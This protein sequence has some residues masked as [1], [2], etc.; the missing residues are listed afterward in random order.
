MSERASGMSGRALLMW[1]AG[2]VAY[3]GAVF[4][5]SSLAVAGVEAADRFHVGAAMLSMLSVVQLAV[6]AAMQVPAGLL[7]D[8]H[9]PRRLLAIGSVLMAAGQLA[10]ALATGIWPALGARMLIGIGD[11]LTFVSLVRVVAAWFPARRNPLLVQLTGAIGQL[12]S[13]ASAVPLVILLRDAGWTVTFLAASGLAVAAAVI[14]GTALRDRPEPVGVEPVGVDAG[15]LTG[16]AESTPAKSSLP[17][18]LA[19]AWAQPGTKLGLWTHFATQFSGTVF[20]LLWG[21]P[22]LLAEGLSPGGAAGMLSLLTC[23]G[24]VAG[25]VIGQLC[26]R[27]PFHRSALV[28]A[29]VGSSAAMWTV[30]LSWPGRVPHWALVAL[31]LVLAVNGPGSM[32]G[33][34]Y[35]RTFN[36]ARRL[37]SATGIVNVGGFTASILLIIGIG[38]TVDAL[39]PAG[40]DGYPLGVLRWAFALQYLLW[41]LGVI[42]VL[43]LRRRTRR[44]LA[45]RDPAAVP[46][47]ALRRLVPVGAD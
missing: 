39:R 38:V 33:F 31:V 32:I 29:I 45:I 7:L 6:Y 44:E 24:I 34:D 9:G 23:A 40:T 26:G 35:A 27:H 12:G 22:F 41:G 13:L 15:V 21:Y 11:A 36:P 5:R 17:A 8:R 3:V 14:V 16:T 28:L 4:Q 46:P 43:R 10:F 47:R 20:G 18:T 2:M 37:G 42:Q 1:A 19:A 25:P 30:V